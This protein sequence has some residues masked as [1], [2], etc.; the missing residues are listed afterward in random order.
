MDIHEGQPG[1]HGGPAALPRRV[2]EHRVGR[3][4]RA[5]RADADGA[6]PGRGGGRRRSGPAAAP[7]PL[8][9]LPG[10]R[11]RAARGAP[12]PARAPHPV[13]RR[14]RARALAG[15]AARRRPDPAPAAPRRAAAVGTP[16]VT[17]GM[18]L[19]SGAGGGRGTAV[20]AL[21][22]LCVGGGAA[23]SYCIATGALPDPT[24]IVRDAGEPREKRTKPAEKREAANVRSRRRTAAGRGGPER[25]HPP[26]AGRDPAPT[27]NPPRRPAAPSAPRRSSGPQQ[28][29]GFESATGSSGGA[30]AAPSPPA[31]TTATTSTPPSSGGGSTTTSPP[32][33]TSGGEFLP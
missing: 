33:P 22:S 17:T 2:R 11:A 13:P 5:L 32:P 6:R 25:A 27:P 20:A 23:G 28:E 9:R 29:F 31:A 12:P 3:G 15:R 8:R 7:A 10:D 18:Q 21:V 24:R 14:H 30:E 1:D 16:D 4:V 26:P 19:A